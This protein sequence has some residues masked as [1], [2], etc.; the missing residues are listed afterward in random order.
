MLKWLENYIRKT[1]QEDEDEQ[2]ERLPRIRWMVAEIGQNF[3]LSL[4]HCYVESEEVLESIPVEDEDLLRKIE[5]AFEREGG[6]FVELNA[7]NTLVVAAF[8]HEGIQL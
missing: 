6:V 5:E 2:R 3:L 4:M 1:R 7:S 8:T